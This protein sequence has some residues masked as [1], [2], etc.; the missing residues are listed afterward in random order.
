MKKI[1]TLLMLLFVALQGNSQG[2]NTELGFNNEYTQYANGVACD[3]AYTYLVIHEGKTGSIDFA[4]Y[5]RSTKLKKIDTLGNVIWNWALAPKSAEYVDNL[6]IAFANDGEIYFFGYARLWYEGPTTLDSYFCFLQKQDTSGNVMW[7]KDWIINDFF[8]TPFTGFT[9]SNAG[10]LLL[11]HTS[12]T[13]S[14][15]YT[16]SPAGVIT[17]SMLIAEPDMEG[18]AELSGF[19]VTG[20]R[21]DSLMGFDSAGMLNHS[22]TFSTAVQEINSMNDTLYVLTQDSIYS[23]SENL[24]PIHASAVPGYSSYRKLKVDGQ[25][26][27]FLSHDSLT[28]TVITLNR[29]LQVT[30]TLTIPETIDQDALIDFNNM[31]LSAGITFNLTEFRA[32]RFLNY[33]MN[34][35]QNATINRTD[36]GV[37]DLVPTMVTAL[38]YGQPASSYSSR[39]EA[40]VLIKNFGLN[41]LNSCRITRYNGLSVMV[42]PTVYAQEFHNLNLAPGDSLWLSLGAIFQGMS[43]PSGNEIKRNVCIHTNHP[44]GLVDLNVSNDQ[45]CKEIIFGYVGIE[46]AE[47]KETFSLYPNPTTG[48]IRFD[49][50]PGAAEYAV[51]NLHGQVVHSGQTTQRQLDLTLLPAGIY[52]VRILSLQHG[53]EI[54]GKVVIVPE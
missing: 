53:K 34:S 15:V 42:N 8:A 18:F 40:D 33:S 24:L 11:N 23:F 5:G 47:R 50:P 9:I 6:R 12:S 17:D 37:V 46:E 2:L 21:N 45:F 52:V 49:L 38:P 44:N 1:I 39:L 20:F 36:I 7:T 16:I 4:G 28:L 31:H 54:A 32:V 26:I 35:A 25:N 27:R 30:D 48:V 51:Y 41:T 13:G 3:G 19:E 29:Q 10:N 22:I 14:W 43:F